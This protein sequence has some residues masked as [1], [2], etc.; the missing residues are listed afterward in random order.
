MV[1]T[2]NTAVPADSLAGNTIDFL[3]RHPPFDEMDDAALGFLASRLAVGYY[4]KDTVIVA[5][6]QG[7]P[8]AFFIIKRGLVHLLP[9]N[10][11]ALTNPAP[12]P[13]GQGEFFSVG[14]LLEQRA[15]TA[16][17]VAGTDTF[18]FELSP[19]DFRDL[20]HRSRRFQEFA[21]R[22]L[23]SLLR[24]SRRLF[25]MQVSGS[26]GEQQAMSRPLRSLMRRELVSCRRDTSVGDALRAMHQAKVGSIVVLEPAGTA[27]GI[28]TR[29]DVVDR[30]VLAQTDLARPI[31]SIMTPDPFTLPAEASAFEAAFA[32]A[33]RGV[34]HF[35]VVDEGR[36]IG[37]V[38]ERDLFALQRVSMR[39]INREVAKAGSPE[40]LQKLAGDIRRLT[41]SLLEQ[42]VA[43]EQMTLII[44]TLND[45]LT[46]RIIELEAR[47]YDLDGIE[48]CWLAFGSEGRF[49]QTISTDQ[50]NG[51]IF[52]DVPGVPPDSTRRRLLPFAQAVNRALDAC[53]FPLCIGNIMAGNPQWCLSRTEWQRQ[54]ASWIANTD[55]E[56]L[57][58]ASIFF[59]FRPICGEED[60]AA[61]L[62]E[63]LFAQ[64]T[65]NGRFLRQ[66]AEQALRTEPP[67][68][69]LRDFAVEDDGTVDL[70]KSGAR[71]FVDAARVISLATGTEH[72]NTAQRLRHGGARVNVKTGEIAAAVDAFFFIQMLRLRQQLAAA[73][74][75]GAHNKL[76]PNELN[77]VDR[78]I[79]KACFRQ[80]RQLQNRLKLDYQL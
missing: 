58:N 14:A 21:T 59:D 2:G 50:D 77:E 9:A 13:L 52:A 36:V 80:A 18:C 48:W 4:P 31:E 45:T 65:V 15:V 55:P 66:L 56:A 1:N 40:T 19:G 47:Q 38:A 35:P 73:G 78:R 8:R 64:T 79:L 44:S 60:F 16:T 62:R 37:V 3:K 54:F 33:H 75:A 25:K 7:E 11:G 74:Q 34:R 61:D 63:K 26:V 67:L 28:L 22:Y 12:H 69:L 39:Q 30:V 20:L 53:G 70:K 29:H 17:Y 5:P 71:L 6:E 32:M 57:L 76:D 43:S 72:T 23:A 24:Q 42:G 10:S 51:L 41:R 27:A 49:E 46:R 68:G